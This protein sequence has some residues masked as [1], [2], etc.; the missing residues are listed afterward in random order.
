MSDDLGPVDD[1]S[2]PSAPARGRSGVEADLYLGR[3]DPLAEAH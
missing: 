2:S 1:G 3:R